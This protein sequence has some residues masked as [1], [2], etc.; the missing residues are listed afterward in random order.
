MGYCWAVGCNH[1][2]QREKCK[3]FTL[4]KDLKSRNRWLKLLKR[5]EQPGREC[6]VCSYHFKNGHRIN[7]PELQDH[8]KKAF[9]NEFPQPPQKRRNQI[10]KK[11]TI[12][13]DTQ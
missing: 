13:T 12:L 8:L 11:V 6:V 7:G 4:P 3:F 5:S 1:H 2:N 9:D 10:T